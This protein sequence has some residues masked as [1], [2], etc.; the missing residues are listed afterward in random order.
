MRLS[1]SEWE[2]FYVITGSSAAA[3][4]GLMFVVVALAAE[5]IQRQQS[6][7]VGAFSTPTVAHFSLVLLIAS[8]MSVPGQSV[9]SLSI[10][11]GGCAVAGLT[12]SGRAGLRMRR[13]E[14]YSPETEDWAF[15]VILPFV[16]YAVLLVSA[17]LIGAAQEL[18]LILV[19]TAVLALIFIG[20]HNA[21]D[22]AVFLVTQHAPIVST[23][24]VTVT[25][26]VTPESV[27]APVAAESD[28]SGSLSPG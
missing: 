12:S 13:L 3:L 7:G 28:G 27:A 21:W 6:D 23:S 18:A 25:P 4:T 20:I 1:L 17:F 10:C 15:H 5:R 24:D 14:A 9:L 26:P 16:A 19:A 8:L 11:I 2:S 22:V